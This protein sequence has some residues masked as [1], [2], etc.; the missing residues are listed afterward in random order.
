MILQYDE[1]FRKHVEDAEAAAPRDRPDMPKS[2]QMVLRGKQQVEAAS[3][4][5]AVGRCSLE[6][7]N[8]SNAVSNT[9]SSDRVE[10]RGWD[11]TWD[12]Q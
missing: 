2:N 7:E 8:L 4:F 9:H 10:I 5:R 3:P 12:A 11:N 1:A 6:K